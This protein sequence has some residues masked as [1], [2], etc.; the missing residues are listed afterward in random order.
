MERPA[1]TT[2][3]HASLLAAIARGEREALRRLYAAESRRLY[4]IALAIL[5]DPAAAADAVQDAF[6]RIWSR[7]GTYDATR[8]EPRTWLAAIARHV[9]L[10][11]ARARGR[12]TPTD[13]PALGDRPVEED[14]VSRLDD[15]ADAARLRACLEGLP[16]KN[17]RSIVLAFVDGFSH[18][19]VAARLELPVGTVKAWIRRGLAS[20]RECLAS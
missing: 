18:S 13:D 6:L 5:R 14:P 10:D 1:D 3:D 9:A 20:L 4:G 11:A 2:G 16:E 12:E 15:A 7:A 17:R 8:G 19:Q